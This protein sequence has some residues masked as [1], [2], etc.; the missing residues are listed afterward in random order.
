[1]AVR[2]C[3]AVRA[4]QGASFTASTERQFY[5]S[6]VDFDAKP[7]SGMKFSELSLRIP[8]QEMSGDNSRGEKL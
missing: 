2:V 7:S 3:R 5:T 8:G 4:L 6:A 1:L